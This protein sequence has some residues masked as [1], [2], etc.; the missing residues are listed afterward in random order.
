MYLVS[1]QQQ[2]NNERMISIMFIFTIY[3][4]FNSKGFNP[5]QSLRVKVICCLWANM[6][7][8]V[9]NHQNKHHFFFL[10]YQTIIDYKVYKQINS[11]NQNSNNSSNCPRKFSILHHKLKTSLKSTINE[12]GLLTRIVVIYSG[13]AQVYSLYYLFDLHS[14]AYSDCWTRDWQR[15]NIQLDEQGSSN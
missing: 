12:Y 8:L 10:F 3:D 11:S 4:S 7:K 14:I 1:S 6:Y 2:S 13:L 15:R 5:E 9:V